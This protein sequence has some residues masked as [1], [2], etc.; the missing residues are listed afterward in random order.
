MRTLKL[1]F[2]LLTLGLLASACGRATPEALQPSPRSDAGPFISIDT[3]VGADASTGSSDTGPALCQ[4]N[5]EPFTL[6]VFGDAN[7]GVPFPYTVEF[8]GDSLILSQA[9][10]DGLLRILYQGPPLFGDLQVGDRVW[11]SV[12]EQFV[13]G[14]RSLF[15]AVFDQS[16]L[17]LLFGVFDSSDLE[18]LIVSGEV[19]DETCAPAPFDTGCGDAVTVRA[20]LL[21]PGGNVAT[22][23]QGEE[24][25]ADGF[26]F[27]LI[28]AYRF[29]DGPCPSVGAGRIAGYVV[30]DP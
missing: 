7:D 24:T 23:G 30:A 28:H 29:L 17:D 3:G 1:S 25:V 16:R 19:N 2:G 6:E 22:V 13:A 21:S 8:I 10:G 4:P 9:V 20:D 18:T 5:T 26:R 15:V 12:D 14:G 27:G 11:V